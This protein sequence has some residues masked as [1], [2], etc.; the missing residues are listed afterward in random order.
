M[1]EEDMANFEVDK[2]LLACVQAVIWLGIEW[3]VRAV[4][5]MVLRTVWKFVYMCGNMVFDLLVHGWCLT[6][7][8]L[9]CEWSDRDYSFPNLWV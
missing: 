7:L 4:A 2:E 5:R 1:I 8:G 6:S 3:M 9:A